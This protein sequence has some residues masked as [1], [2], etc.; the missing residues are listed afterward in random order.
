[1]I[2]AQSFFRNGQRPLI[3][4]FNAHSPAVNLQVEGQIIQAEGNTWVF[5]PQGPFFATQSPSAE[6]FSFYDFTSFEK[7]DGKILQALTVIGWS[8]PRLLCRMA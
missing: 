7:K 4:G 6:A 1:M 2:R 3:E 5:L 8:G